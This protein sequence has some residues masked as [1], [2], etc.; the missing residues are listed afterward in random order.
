MSDYEQ[1]LANISAQIEKGETPQKISVRDFLGWFSAQRRGYYIVGDIE[2]ALKKYDLVTRPNFVFAYIDADISFSRTPREEPK[3]E[4]ASEAVGKRVGDPTYRIG[5]LASANRAPLSVKPDATLS[6]AITFMLSNDY[7]QLPVMTS[8]RNVKGIISWSSI[9]SRLALGKTCEYVRD[10][11]DQYVEISSETSLFDAI[12]D[13]ISNQYVLIRGMDSTITGIVT[14]SDLSVQFQQLGE[15]FLLLGEIEN[16]IRKM[17]QDKFTPEELLE[18]RDPKDAERDVHSVEDL[19]FGEYVR[20]LENPDRWSNL[21]LSID[22][23]IFIKQLEQ[24]RMIR[25]D[26]M[27]FDPDG[28]ADSDLEILRD[29]VRF[30]QGL[31]NIGVI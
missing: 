13:I 18:A 28:I 14:T 24:I 16:Y 31:A 23:T 17:I 27:H 25:N 15:P 29:F 20:L 1:K 6:E 12:D 10:C 26:V 11:M 3:V 2:R 5:K 4:K 19:T 7:S 21:G 9:G 22:R 8:E 30:L